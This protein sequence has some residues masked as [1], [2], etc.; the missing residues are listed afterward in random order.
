HLGH[1]LPTPASDAE[2]AINGRLAALETRA[3]QFR[4]FGV[5]LLTRVSLANRLLGSRL[6]HTISVGPLP[7]T[8]R[9]T[10]ISSLLPYLTNGHSWVASSTLFASPRVGG[11]GL[12]DPDAMATGLSISFCRAGSS[13]PPSSANGCGLGSRPTSS[14]GTTFPPPSSSSGGA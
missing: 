5:E 9:R 7:V 6:W 8:L 3:R 4:T 12:I 10:Y 14:H 2:S 1:P 11:F 13:P